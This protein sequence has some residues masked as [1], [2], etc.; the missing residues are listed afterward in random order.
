MV[1]TTLNPQ[2]PIIEEHRLSDPIQGEQ[3]VRVLLPR[4]VRLRQG[5][6]DS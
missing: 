2:I 1:F 3:Y 4:M 5:R 6:V